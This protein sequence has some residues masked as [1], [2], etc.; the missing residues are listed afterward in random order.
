MFVKIAAVVLIAFQC[1]IGSLQITVAN[2]FGHCIKQ[3]NPSFITCAGQQAIETLQQFSDAN[4]LTL[5]EGLVLSKEESVMGRN[6]PI[7]FLDQD[8]NDFRLVVLIRI[9]EGLR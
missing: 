6:N 1:V 7:N 4:N 2:S 5:T 8:P 9:L 3:E